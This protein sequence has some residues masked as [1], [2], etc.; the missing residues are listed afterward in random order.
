MLLIPETVLERHS[1]TIRVQRPFVPAEIRPAFFAAAVSAFTVSALLGLVIALV[2]SFLGKELHQRN[3]AVAGLVVFLLF[4][5]ATVAQL[6]LHR[7]TSRHA[8]LIGFAWLLL[9]L[10]LLML[11][12]DMAEI[13][14]FVAGIVCAGIGTGLVM[15][16]ALATVNRIAPPE[17]RAEI[18]SGFFVSAYAG[19]AI[20]ALG[21]GIASQHVGFFRA[22]LVCSI[23]LAVLLG[24]VAVRVLGAP[25]TVRR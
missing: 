18:M 8:L 24:T 17:H 16:G 21:V 3:H 14:V 19:L 23:V 20:P 15:M 9:G 6:L 11:G 7:L 13:A 12:L 4:S 5:V 10:G 2:P 1:P 22:T 25:G